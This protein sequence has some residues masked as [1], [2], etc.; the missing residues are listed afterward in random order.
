[1]L[2][3]DWQWRGPHAISSFW[4]H[5]RRPSKNSGTG[6][7]VYLGATPTSS[8]QCMFLI[9]WDSRMRSFNLI[10]EFTIFLVLQLFT[11]YYELYFQASHHTL[12][13][14]AVIV[15][16]LLLWSK[17]RHSA[18][19]LNSPLKNHPW[20]SLKLELYLTPHFGHWFQES[21]FLIIILPQQPTLCEALM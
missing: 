5:K 16:D 8:N 10:L 14:N 9:L 6:S 19:P 1:M 12:P 21:S 11:R 20:V 17:D 4:P 2:E 3:G 18:H 7:T 13:N 15:W